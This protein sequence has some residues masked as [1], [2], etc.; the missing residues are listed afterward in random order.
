MVTTRGR[1]QFRYV[2]M[3][4]KELSRRDRVVAY[5]TRTGR[6]FEFHVDRVLGDSSY[7]RQHPS[8]SSLATIV[9]C[10]EPY[11]KIP[12]DALEGEK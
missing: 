8:G 9:H 12:A 2:E 1:K 11:Y 10:S 4:E 5:R 3:Q 6:V 7:C